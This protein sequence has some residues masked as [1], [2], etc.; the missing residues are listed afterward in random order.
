MKSVGPREAGTEDVAGW[1]GLIL[2]SDPERN[3]QR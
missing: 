2:Y 1:T 3:G